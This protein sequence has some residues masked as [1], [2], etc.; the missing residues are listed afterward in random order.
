MSDLW[1]ELR[2]IHIYKLSKEEKEGLQM[3]ITPF[4][5]YMKIN[6]DGKSYYKVRSELTSGELKTRM[7]LPPSPST[8]RTNDLLDENDPIIIPVETY[9]LYED[10]K[11]ENKSTKHNVFIKISEGGTYAM[12]QDETLKN[13]KTFSVAYLKSILSKMSTS[14]IDNT[15]IFTNYEDQKKFRSKPAKSPEYQDA[16]ELHLIKDDVRFPV[17][18]MKGK[19]IE[20]ISYQLVLAYETSNELKSHSQK[21]VEVFKKYGITNL[22]L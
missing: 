14:G 12:S 8:S 9:E 18:K 2:Q 7:T 1:L 22:T 15:F 3:P 20:N 5:P 10:P 6:M 13:F 17:M 16:I 11:T 19:Y 4:A 21:L